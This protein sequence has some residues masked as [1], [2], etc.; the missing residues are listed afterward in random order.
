MW[1]FMKFSFF[2][3]PFIFLEIFG[4]SLN[5]SNSSL[6]EANEKQLEQKSKGN[7]LKSFMF[8]VG[9]VTIQSLSGFIAYS[10]LLHS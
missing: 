10:Y 3:E 9:I 2:L 4:C 8:N 7:V 1:F 5:F 6:I